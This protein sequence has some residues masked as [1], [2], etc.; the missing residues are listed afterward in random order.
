VIAL[1]N[2][3]PLSILTA[4]GLDTPTSV[5]PIKGGADAAIWQVEHAGNHYA[6]RVLRPDQSGQARRETVAMT[7]AETGRVPVPSIVANATWEERP[8]LLLTWSPGQPL[9]AALLDEP[10]NLSH[11][12][13]L[14][15]EFGRVQ[16]AIHALPPPAELPD[17]STFW[18]SS[19]VP[20]SALAACLA[21][22]PSR[23]PALLHLDYHPLN[24]LVEGERVTAVLDWANARG[25]DPRFDLA[26]T[27]SILRLAPLPPSLPEKAARTMRRAFETGWRRGYEQA[28]GPLGNLTPFC[29]W[30]GALMERDLAPRVGRPDIPWLTPAYLARVRRW[31]GG[32]RTRA[33]HS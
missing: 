1:N 28:A 4:L 33:T 9:S 7:A 6:L 27:L 2:L 22:T 20:E 5:Q 32:W 13:A 16:A 29:W 14:G 8:V 19:T 30:A 26:R 23:P 25:G 11:A 18:E 15:T 17:R 24:V 12:R 3:D 21:A 31:T 10:Q